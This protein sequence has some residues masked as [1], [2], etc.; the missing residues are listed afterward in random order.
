MAF[1]VV[2]LAVVV[3]VAHAAVDDV[4][5]GIIYRSP[6]KNANHIPRAAIFWVLIGP[7]VCYSI[8]GQGQT[9]A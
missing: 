9:R 4:I 7:N 6:P 8:L 1:S 3:V 5:L 2:V